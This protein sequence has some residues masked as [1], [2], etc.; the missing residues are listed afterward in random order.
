[1][2]PLPGA[3]VDLNRRQAEWLR[4]RPRGASFKAA[5][6][7]A[8]FDVSSRTA[9][10]DLGELRRRGLVERKGAGPGSYWVRV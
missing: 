4:D 7:A 1:M 9:L 10:N 8:T 3:G 6:Y 2:L 5:E